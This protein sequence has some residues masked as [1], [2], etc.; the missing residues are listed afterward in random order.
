MLRCV[1]LRLLGDGG[2]ERRRSLLFRD[3]ASESGQSSWLLGRVSF[4]P[5]AWLVRGTRPRGVGLG[6]SRASAYCG[7][8]AVRERGQA[9]DEGIV[10]RCGCGWTSCGGRT[11]E[12]D[13]IVSL[14]LGGSNDIA[15]LYPEKA[16]LPG[17]AP[18]LPRERQTGERRAQGGV[19]RNDQPPLG[20]AADRFELGAA[21]QEAVRGRTD[22]LMGRRQ[23][24]RPAAD[25]VDKRAARIDKSFG[26]SPD[27][28]HAARA[29][30]SGTIT[31]T[32]ARIRRPIVRRAS[33]RG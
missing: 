33:V 30:V 3:L 19:H 16:T 7:Q 32:N 12:I 8:R 14:E 23:R 9:G 4:A 25:P 2:P 31:S 10:D 22:R 26:S 17:H 13:H 1:R 28:R 18:G 20:P 21:L 27:A 29:G 5:L 11:L 6:A 15:N 24:L